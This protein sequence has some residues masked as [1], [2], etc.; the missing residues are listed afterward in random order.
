MAQRFTLGLTYLNSSNS[1]WGGIP[2]IK[3]IARVRTNIFKHP[4]KTRDITPIVTVTKIIANG[5]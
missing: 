1:T 2:G 4:V 5:N 3:V